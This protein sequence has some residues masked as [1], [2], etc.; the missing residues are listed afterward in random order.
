[1]NEI[2]GCAETIIE[3]VEKFIETLSELIGVEPM[4][5]KELR[6]DPEDL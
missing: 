1:V 5:F 4:N 6:L 2:N 3:L